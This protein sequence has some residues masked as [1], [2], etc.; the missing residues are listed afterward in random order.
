MKNTKTIAKLLLQ[1]VLGA[2]GGPCKDWKRAIRL[3]AYGLLKKNAEV[4]TV[5]H[6]KTCSACRLFLLECFNGQE[7][8]VAAYT[9]N[10]I[11][12]NASSNPAVVNFKLGSEEDGFVQE[13]PSS[14]TDSFTSP[15]IKHYAEECN[16]AKKKKGENKNGKK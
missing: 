3:F 6:I 2:M 12:K 11:A 16:P 13:L 10:A 15:E 14:D 5:E 9:R 8:F 1:P 4:K 7:Q